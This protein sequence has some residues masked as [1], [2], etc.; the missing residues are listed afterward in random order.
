MDGGGMS[1][2]RKKKPSLPVSY[3]AHRCV[4][5]AI[6]P[7]KVSGWA[8]FLCGRLIAVGTVRKASELQ[9]VIDDAQQLAHKESLRLIVVAETW[10]AGGWKSHKQLIGMGASWGR[11]ALA[12]E[13]AG[14]PVRRIV[15]VSVQTWR[16]VVLG[17]ARTK[18]AA[19]RYARARW[20]AFTFPTD[21]AAEAACQG[22]WGCQA[23]EVLAVLPTRLLP[24]P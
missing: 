5:L 14:H 13:L 15:R 9:K 1:R 18:H 21:D 24:G 22:A 3:K 19:E 6:D 2:R 7:G 8:L 23:G 16:S 12:L 17:G 10:E 11:W 20:P 4:V